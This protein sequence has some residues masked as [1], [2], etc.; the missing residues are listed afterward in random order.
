M[1]KEG[2]ER[3]MAREGGKG[4]DESELGDRAGR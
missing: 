3:V 2:G 4:E 1:R